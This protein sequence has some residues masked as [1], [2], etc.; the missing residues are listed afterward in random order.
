[1]RFRSVIA[2]IVMC[3]VR[4]PAAHSQPM[5]PAPFTV[6]TDAGDTLM[7][8]AGIAPGASSG[9]DDSLGE[10][11]IPPPPPDGIFDARFAD[12][13]TTRRALGEGTW[14]DLR[15]GDPAGVGVQHHLLL[16]RRGAGTTVAISW[17]LPSGVAALVELRDVVPPRSIMATG[18]GSAPLGTMGPLI[19]MHI[20][21]HY[22]VRLL[23][24]RMMLEGPF[25]PRTGRM[26]TSLRASGI[27]A[28]RFPGR[29]LPAKAVDS[30]GVEL[31]GLAAEPDAEERLAQPAWLTEDGTVCPFDPPFD[32]PLV[33]P[34]PLQH[35]LYP[36][37]FHRNHLA[38]LCTRPIPAGVTAGE[39]DMTS[40]SELYDGGNAARLA[41]SL[42]GLR[43]GDADGDGLIG[44]W[45]RTAVRTAVGRARV[46]DRCDVD[47]NGGVGATDLALVRRG[48]GAPMK[49]P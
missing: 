18:R 16:C 46:Y 32:A 3:M 15:T 26:R 25:E 20:T 43:V 47:L 38:V 21:L 13:D 6:S 29:S 12:P 17:D 35:E 10:A 30:I 2:V 39:C 5:L 40:G 28:E 7:V 24:A 4:V 19:T 14:I 33:F 42:W 23:T 22:N 34:D 45:D 41:P 37:F 49:E 36:A 31:R 27:L 48:I 9:I 8:C 11:E 1:M 44:T